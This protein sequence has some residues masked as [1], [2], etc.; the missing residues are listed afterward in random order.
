MGVQRI[1]DPTAVAARPPVPALAGILGYFF[2][3]NPA[4]GQGATVVPDWW[5][6]MVQ[7][8]MV[9]FLTAAGLPIDG[10]ATFL[11]A[12]TALFQAKAGGQAALGFT[13]VQQ[14]TG[15]GQLTNVV[16]LGWSAGARLKA[17]I[18]NT[19][20]GNL[21]TDIYATAIA[22]L[23]VIRIPISNY[24]AAATLRV[25]FG[26]G[27]TGST[28]TFNVVYPEPFT[29]FVC[30]FIAGTLGSSAPGSVLIE[31]GAPAL[32]YCPVIATDAS[33]GSPN[34]QSGGDASFS[35]LAIGI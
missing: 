2:G 23:G 30:A 4:T 20:L 17:T 33:H 10:S 28:G 5:L 25:Q 27:R 34:G 14:G 9:A 16:K 35:W 15:V 32:T 1:Q 12:A 7:E 26:I 3:G 8:E 18:D 11:Q 31:A 13:P 22:S 24:G 21:M 19:D 29:N 6:N